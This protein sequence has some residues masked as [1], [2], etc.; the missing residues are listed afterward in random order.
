MPEAGLFA[1]WWPA[2]EA[3]IRP[4]L[5][6]RGHCH[7]DIEDIVQATAEKA[8]RHDRFDSQTHL[9]A[10]SLVVAKNSSTDIFRR[11]GRELLDS[12]PDFASS[13]DV[14]DTVTTL[15]T[16]D[17]L[18]ATITA[19]PDQQRLALFAAETPATRKDAIRI[20][21]IRHRVRKRLRHVYEGLAA[22]FGRFATKTG[23]WWQQFSD[24]SSGY[25]AAAIAVGVAGLV[26]LGQLV[27]PTTQRSAAE[28]PRA[29]IVRR[30]VGPVA[31]GAVL[32][33]AP[34]PSESQPRAPSQPRVRV[35]V[36]HD[37]GGNPEGVTVGPRKENQ[38]KIACVGHTA[39]TPGV[40]APVAAHAITDLL[41]V[42]P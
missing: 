38:T 6:A 21:V 3:R 25:G 18:M 20:A 24:S 13:L 26:V 2:A 4:L 9:L 19:L 17:E 16:R 36:G 1:A 28:T 39:A 11:H 30:V 12:V 10:W 42:G 29:P 5:Q 22:A 27:S 15:V 33:D 23:S 40:C 32:S 8:L 34:R 14:A 31:A 35:T 41:P 7:D 37:R